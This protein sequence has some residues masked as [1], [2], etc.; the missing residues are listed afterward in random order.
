MH[1][2]VVTFCNGQGISS[3][4]FLQKRAQQSTFDIQRNLHSNAINLH[5]TLFHCSQ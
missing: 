4:P 5:L 2:R 3:F 1:G